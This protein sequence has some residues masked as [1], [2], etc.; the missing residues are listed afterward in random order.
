[1]ANLLVI[2]SSSA[3][4]YTGSATRVADAAASCAKISSSIG[5]RYLAAAAL[6]SSG[7]GIGERGN[8]VVA[9]GSVALGVSCV[10]SGSAVH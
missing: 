1:M 6:S 9:A 3:S 4:L 5:L 7:S 10:C 8:R 2:L